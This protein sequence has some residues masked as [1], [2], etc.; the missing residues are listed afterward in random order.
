MVHV[1]LGVI[2]V[3]LRGVNY[4]NQHMV[5]HLWLEFRKPIQIAH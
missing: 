4:T 1:I 5:Q 3:W 2:T